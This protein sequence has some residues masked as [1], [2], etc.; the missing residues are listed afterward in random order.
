M[1]LFITTFSIITPRKFLSNRDTTHNDTQYW[2]SLYSMSLRRVSNMLSVT[3]KLIKLVVFKLIT[4]CWVSLCR[5]LCCLK[6]A[7]ISIKR[8]TP[9]RTVLAVG[10]GSQ[11]GCS[12]EKE[13]Y[14]SDLKVSK[15]QL[16]NHT[17]IHYWLSSKGNIGQ[18][19]RTWNS[20]LV[21][22]VRTSIGIEENQP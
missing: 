15:F 4:L 21:C 5:I 14:H 1:T 13:D 2:V 19:Q 12:K 6:K 9:R 8:L 22:I 18:K 11:Y 10:I 3:N 16:L 17:G 7:K 20:Y